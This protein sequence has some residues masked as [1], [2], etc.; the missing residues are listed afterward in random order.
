MAEAAG[1]GL[2]GKRLLVVEDE[3]MIARD[4]TW[5]L[6]GAGAQVVGPVGTVAGALQLIE[7]GGRLDGAVLD[8]SLRDELV[9]PVADALVA[10]GVPFVFATGYD[11]AIVPPHYTHTPRCEKPVDKLKLM[12]LLQAQ[13][14]EST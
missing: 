10:R 9:Y 11:R 5:A 8:I 2:A 4:L 1:K 14:V 6:E 12:R 7:S 3:Y 13:F